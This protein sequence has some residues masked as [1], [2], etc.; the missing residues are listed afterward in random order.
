V[1]FTDPILSSTTGIDIS[2]SEKF[3]LIASSNG[4]DLYSVKPFQ[5][6]KTVIEGKPIFSPIF[7]DDNN[8][9]FWQ[10]HPTNGYIFSTQGV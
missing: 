6:I 10:K 4:L 8:I 2:A 3:A 7:L 1:L 9:G 5:K